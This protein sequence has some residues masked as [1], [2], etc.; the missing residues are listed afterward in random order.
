[1]GYYQ[2]I[3][4][5]YG[6]NATAVLKQWARTNIKLANKTNRR[7]FLLRC[8]KGNILPDHIAHNNRHITNMLDTTHGTIGS[9]INKFNLRLGKQVLNFEINITCSDI[10]SLNNII[11]NCKTS[12]FSLLPNHVVNDF[13]SWQDRT[14]NKQFNKIK[15]KNIPKF[16]RLQSNVV[17][18]RLFND[19][20]KWFINL[21]NI[22]IPTDISDLLSLGPK[23]SVPT[24]KKDTNIARLV[25]N[26]E[27]IIEAHP[28]HTRDTLRAQATNIITNFLHRDDEMGGCNL[29][30]DKCRKFLKENPNILILKADKGAVTVAMDADSYYEKASSLLDDTNTYK[31]LSNDPTS[32]F[33]KR[34]NDLVNILLKKGM[35]DEILA[36]KL[37]IY[38]ATAPKFHAFPKIHK[39]NIPLRPIVASINTPTTAI[40]AFVAG[41]LTVA[42]GN[43]RDYNIINSFE[44]AE[45]YNNFQL[46]ADHVL[47]SFDVVSLF[48]NIP[49]DLV[50]EV[51]T[52]KWDIIQQH[53]SLDLDNFIRVVKFIF[54]TSYLSYRDE[55]LLQIFGTPMGS[56]LSPILSSIVMDYLLDKLMTLIQ[57]QIP[58]LRK[59]VDDLICGIPSDMVELTLA[60]LNSLNDHIQFTVEMEDDN[61][62]VPFLDTRVIRTAE[63]T[64][65]LDW[66]QKPTSSGRYI[67]FYSS[68]P[69]SVKNNIIIAM[70]NRITKICHPDYREK[71]LK[72][73]FKMFSN[74][75]YPSNMLKKLIY[76]SATGRVDNILP[77]DRE[78]EPIPLAVYRKLPNIPRIT[79]KLANVLHCDNIKIARYN[80]KCI[81]EFFSSTKSKTP[82]L[83]KSNVVYSIPCRD[84]EKVYVGQTGQW[85]KSRLASHRSEIRNDKRCC[86][87]SAH[88]NNHSHTV[89]FDNVKVLDTENQYKTRLFLEM[90]HI[91]NCDNTMNYKTDMDDLNS[92][93]SYIFKKHNFINTNSDSFD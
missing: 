77:D 28:P 93:Y 51:I 60:T 66:Y 6:H 63:S 88:A 13:I 9:R 14:F 76:N 27:S 90:W 4:H 45:Q 83:L 53:C 71:N 5:N 29:P 22:T 18:D 74:N 7:I 91:N 8:R 50:I 67:N 58:F 35:I 20:S 32:T 42:L 24:N 3:T 62:S 92:I 40:S 80:P 56:T 84:C 31:K 1:M 69:I 17:S 15:R 46:P 59:Y 61:N 64:I 87:L 10:K 43:H 49:L 16:T 25:A 72:I 23:F 11:N 65:A 81:R 75:G 73:L 52:I 79:N 86:A 48:T 82:I 21:T 2:N 12:A 38:N 39:E 41:I 30:W 68:H 70:K 47:V 78:E 89:D 85:L 57:F 19:N 54:D 34:N 44:F 55:F 36:K 37:K 33:Q 26:V